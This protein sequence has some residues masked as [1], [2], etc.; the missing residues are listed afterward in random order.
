MPIDL[1]LADIA[2]PLFLPANRLDRL[3]KALAAGADAVILDLEDAVAPADRVAAR[4]ALGE[5]LTTARDLP[6]LVRISAGGTPDFEADLACCA[7]LPIAGVMLA[8]ADDGAVCERVARDGGVP[9]V[10]LVES[11]R[12]LHRVHEVAGACARLAFGSIDFAADLG[13]AHER[14]PLAQARFGLAMASRLAG[15]PPPWDGVT[16]SLDDAGLV[17][18]DVRHGLDMGMGGK[19]LIHPAQVVPARTALAP[20]EAERAWALRVIAAAADDADALELDGEMID[21]P[22]VL[23]A[24][25]ILARAATDR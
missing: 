6:I 22:V 19:L 3:E 2:L 24:Q 8:K 11:V 25:A 17:A 21:P 18:E 9:V 4:R 14:L 10:G 20:T 7:D 15:L 13:L 23:R 12:G 16:T 1:P 5:T